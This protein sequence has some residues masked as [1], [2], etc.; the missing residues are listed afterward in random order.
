MNSLFSAR[1]LHARTRRLSRRRNWSLDPLEPRVVLTTAYALTTNDHVITFDTTT[2]GTITKDVAYTGTGDEQLISL[3]YRPQT[4]Q[5]IAL[6][7]NGRLY[8]LNATTGVATLMTATAISPFDSST[9][10]YGADFNPTV[11]RLRVVSENDNNLRVNVVTAATTTDTNL[12][13]GI[14]DISLP[15]NPTITGVAYTNSY[16]DA[17]STSLYAIDSALNIL[18]RI[19]N[20]NGGVATTVGPLGVDVQSALGFDIV[21]GTNQAYMAAYIEP[22][23]S[24]FYSINLTTGAATLVAAFP[25]GTQVTSLALT[26][27]THIVRMFRSYNNSPDD[28]FYTTS[29][30][31]FRNSVNAYNYV[32]EAS[33]RSGFGVWQGPTFNASN[34]YRVY[35]PFSGIHYYTMNADERSGLLNIGFQDE[36]TMGYMYKTQQPGTT[37]IYHLYNQKSGGH[38]FTESL[39]TAQA[40]VA[41]FPNDW[42]Q[43]T[44]LGFA[45]AL[46]SQFQKDGSPSVS[47]PLVIATSA[48]ASTTTEASAED[49]NLASL[50]ASSST[51]TI[52][53]SSVQ[54]GDND[55]QNGTV[56]STGGSAEA[57][58]DSAADADLVFSAGLGSL[59]DDLI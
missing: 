51:S 1:T 43:Q 17:A 15:S 22:G 6:G 2:P 56:G 38:L 50:V 23:A 46:G 16:K 47:A 18:A 5:L 34:V 58:S 19:D 11:D 14:G 54:A 41:Q 49:S 40:I 52:S 59:L 28:H 33:G 29:E 36:G 30:A 37:E 20:P 26:Q 32:D 4:D 44:S 35:N 9:T 42:A 48:S 24:G 31:E 21:E 3:D 55:D 25:Q 57:S 12:T 53:Q 13:Y 8:R 39:A 27:D 10:A 7:E 45:Y